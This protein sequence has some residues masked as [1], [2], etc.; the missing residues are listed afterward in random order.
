M[1]HNFQY[2]HRQKKFPATFVA[3]FT[4]VCFIDE[5]LH[6]KKPLKNGRYCPD[7][8]YF[9]IENV[10]AIPEVEIFDSS[11]NEI[12]LCVLTLMAFPYSV[13]HMD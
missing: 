9:G 7:L 1:K 6:K 3:H 11:V 10:L 12:R 4:P 5:E 13:M 8:R 2:L